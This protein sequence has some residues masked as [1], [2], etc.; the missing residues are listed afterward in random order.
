[1]LLG[2]DHESQ[3][4]QARA[5]DPE[6]L[7]R[8][9]RRRSRRRRAARAG[10]LSI[11]L[12]CV[13]AT[14][15]LS[16]SGARRPT[17]VPAANSA[18]AVP[19]GRAVALATAGPVA[20]AQDG[21]LYVADTARHRVLARSAD[22]SFRVI[23]GDGRI[24]FAGD[25]G[26]ATRAQLS[27]ITDLAVSPA[28]DLYIADG[29]RIRVVNHN[30]IIRTIAGDGRPL[31]ISH[32]EQVAG[33][34]AGT[35]ARQ[36]ALGSP[37]SNG[38]VPMIAFSKRGQ[39]YIS[40]GVQVA[41]LTAAGTLVPIRA[42]VTTGPQVLRG[43]LRGFGPI[44][45]DAHG[46]IDVAGFNG[47]SVWQI[48][49]SGRVREIGSGS[50]ARRSGGGYSVLERSPTG[51]VYGENGPELLQIDGND[52]QPVLNFGGSFWLAYFTFG[53]RGR[54]YADEIPGDG[55][56]EARQQLLGLSNR[57]RTLLWEQ[58]RQAKH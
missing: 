6:A 37:R 4:L 27:T 46:N 30:G 15:F 1:M 34:H 16:D 45:I 23:A 29:G 20:V 40:T 14:V 55:G 22:G 56:F 19:A 21:T 49:P 8:E 25:G 57:H 11:V 10:A 36:A 26:L 42:V 47:W 12:A 38:E 48:T 9:A 3:I 41:R 39:L 54:I 7:I 28:G 5:D 32:Q 35:V 51:Q 50:G 17:G 52:L 24:G 43:P 44:A 2:H 53:P 58:P 33:I 31:P 18:A 13:A